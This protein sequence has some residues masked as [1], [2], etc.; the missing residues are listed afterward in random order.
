[1]FKKILIP[2][3]GSVF[4]HDA[5]EQGLNLAKMCGG[6]V[7]FLFAV[8][9]PYQPFQ[10]YATQP[11]E[12]FDRLMAEY[13]TRA[14]LALGRISEEAAISGVQ[15]RAL[16]VEADPIPAILS[17]ARE[18]DLVVMATHGRTGLDRMLMG[19]VTETVLHSCTTPVLVVRG[20]S[21]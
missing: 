20:A 4:G 1:M 9:N 10:N 14:E 18:H 15:A 5:L 2:T 11:R 7:T 8:E 12:Y 16:I 6:E 17:A 21:A 3:D 13:K 19:S